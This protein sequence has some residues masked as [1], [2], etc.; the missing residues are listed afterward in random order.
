MFRANASFRG[1]QFTRHLALASAV[2]LMCAGSPVR[3]SSMAAPWVVIIEGP[4]LPQRVVIIDWRANMALLQGTRRAPLTTEERQERSRHKVALFWGPRFAL[5]RTP[6][7]LAR[8]ES[9]SANQHGILYLA[10]QSEPVTLVVGLGE[11]FMPGGTFQL[12]DTSL[13]VLRQ[14]GVPLR[15]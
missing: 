6:E 3:R 9:S 14:Y 12:A 15:D 2:L 7:S 5:Y 8:L 10:R 4:R 1:L 11:G 13:A